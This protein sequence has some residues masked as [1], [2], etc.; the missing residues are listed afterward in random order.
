MDH[1][2]IDDEDVLRVVEGARDA[3]DERFRDFHSAALAIRRQRV[4]MR[5][6]QSTKEKRLTRVGSRWWACS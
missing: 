6:E 5:V 1:E 2:R 4:A 3:L